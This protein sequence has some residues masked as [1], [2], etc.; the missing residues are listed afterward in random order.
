M[1]TAMHRAKKAFT[2]KYGLVPV[3][4]EDERWA[5]TTFV[6]GRTASLSDEPMP[7]RKLSDTDRANR[8][9]FPLLKRLELWRDRW[10]RLCATAHVECWP[11]REQV[12]LMRQHGLQVEVIRTRSWDDKNRA[13]LMVYRWHPL[14]P[15]STSALDALAASAR[16][17]VEGLVQ[18][19]LSE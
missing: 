17:H 11:S 4:D 5:R 2:E 9:I 3:P 12:D 19:R 10:K 18:S 8:I 6:L 14:E 1:K 16:R 13:V 7:G 15:L